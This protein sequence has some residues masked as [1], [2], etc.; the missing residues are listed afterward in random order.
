MTITVGGRGPVDICQ[1]RFEL[2]SP[3]R[4]ALLPTDNFRAPRRASTPQI[5]TLSA[6]PW[7]AVSR[8]LSVGEHNVLAY[9]SLVPAGTNPK[10]P[11]QLTVVPKHDG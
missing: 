6:P 2:F 3:K 9:V 10:S 4:T 7:G 5:V 8:K 1:P 11:H